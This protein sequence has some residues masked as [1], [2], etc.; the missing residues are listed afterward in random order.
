MV[1]PGK[2]VTS[3]PVAMRMFLVWDLVGAAV[4]LDG[5]DEVGAGDDAVTVHARHLVALKQMRDAA[6]Q[7]RN[8]LLLLRHHHWQIQFYVIKLDPAILKI[9][10]VCLMI[11]MAVVE[12]RFRRDATDVETRSS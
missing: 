7:T 11:K 3:L 8:R 12:Q 4:R 1:M 6:G 9:G 10:P 5:L 2:G